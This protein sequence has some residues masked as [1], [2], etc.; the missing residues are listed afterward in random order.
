MIRE[1]T[2]IRCA[3]QYRGNPCRRFLGVFVAIYGGIKCS[4]C[5]HWNEIRIGDLLDT[6]RSFVAN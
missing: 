3:G 2:S 5:G 4:R 6:P 1:G